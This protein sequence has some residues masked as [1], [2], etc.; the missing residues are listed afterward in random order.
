MTRIISLTALVAAL[1]ASSAARPSP[2]T[3]VVHEKRGA[4]SAR[5]GDAMR[6]RPDAD[7][8]VKIGLSQ[9]NLH[10]GHD[11]LMDVSDPSSENY[12]KFWTEDE[13]HDMFAPSDESVSAVKH[14]LASSGIHEIRITHS[15]NKGW[16]A[17]IASGNE[18][19]N[20]LH[21]DFYEYV[22]SET[23][24]KAIATEQYHVPK[25]IQEHIDYINP[26]IRLPYLRKRGAEAR[27]KRSSISKIYKPPQ[28][29]PAPK[30]GP[31]SANTTG[32][33]KLITPDCVAA[34]Y[35]IPPVSVT[36]S[37]NNSLGIFEEGD[38]Y[39][40]SDLD[41]FFTRFPSYKIPNGT[42]PT[43]AFIDG[44][45]APQQYAGG[46]SNLDFMLAYP[47][48][49]PQNITLFQTDDS[50]YAAGYSEGFF[51][52]FLD[53][54][55]GS[56]CTSCYAGECGN[57]PKDPVYPDTN[58]T[59]GY[60]GKLMCGTYK[61][62]NVI[63]V[64]YGGAED[65]VPQYYYE[66]QCNE[67]MKLGLRGVSIFFSSG[68]SGVASRNGCLGNSTIFN[69]GWP[70]S[71]PYITSVGA[72]K[73]PE[74][75]TVTDPEVAANDPAGHPYSSAYATGG[76]FSNIFGIPD[77]QADAVANYFEKHNPP[78]PYYNGSK[79]GENG[80]L[81]NRSGRGYPDVSANGDNIAVYVNGESSFSGGTSA[82]SPIFAS[83]VNRI[84]DERIAAGKSGPLGFLNPILYKNADAF[85]DITEGTN[86]GCGTDGFSTAPGWDPVT[87]L[88]TPNYPK[89]KEVLL[90]A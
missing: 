18:L 16:L 70:A 86:S 73:L 60:K 3:H 33:D 4:I 8:H 88:G 51:N 48:I 39:A 85:N 42:A 78:Y 6:V 27:S 62:T 71:C 72:T 11:M 25:H 67:F 5:W 21:T 12:G 46:E 17:F 37:P 32:C 35:N 57:D 36:P 44:A 10:R 65:A 29:R 24:D 61:P 81:Y 34:L 63:S 22:D 14:W 84:I 26:G 20:L 53:A 66:R 49:Y 64:S 79:L 87:G 54:I 59:S 56:Y 30:F 75:R 90:N 15:D 9:S 89:L 69:P 68:D 58:S 1:A 31:M 40:Q 2:H 43:P 7:M 77:Y 23:G 80:G 74:N 83:I 50:Y 76:G 13:V 41:S 52:T 45:K 38:Y 55:D 19:E 28:T 82:S 47:I